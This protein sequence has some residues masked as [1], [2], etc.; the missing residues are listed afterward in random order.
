MGLGLGSERASRYGSV[1]GMVV[2]V[3]WDPGSAQYVLRYCRSSHRLT[4][5]RVMDENFAAGRRSKSHEGICRLPS[6]VEHIT[7]QPDGTEAMALETMALC[8]RVGSISRSSRL[9]DPV[10][11]EYQK[12]Q[13]RDEGQ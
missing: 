10:F 3:D 2:I 4:G 7:E 8:C 5:H 1:H 11:G 13:D 6:G 9:Q 12:A